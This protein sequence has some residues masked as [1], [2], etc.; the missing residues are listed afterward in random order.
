MKKRKYDI[1]V[2]V[3]KDHFLRSIGFSKFSV[4][5][6]TWNVSYFS[7]PNIIGVWCELRIPYDY[8][9]QEGVISFL[10]LPAGFW[11]NMFT[12]LN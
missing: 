1:R 8:Q 6:F 2:N 11:K 12:K 5:S 7:K 4:S 3:E 10:Q 9:I